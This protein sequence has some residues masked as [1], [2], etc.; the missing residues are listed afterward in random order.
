MISII[1]PTKN[2]EQNILNTVSHLQ[3]LRQ[4]TYC[5]IILVD[6]MSNDKTVQL[7]KPYVDKIIYSIPN[8]GIQQ[9]KGAAIAEG[10]MV[11]FLHADTHI[12]A[13]QIYMINEIIDDNSWGFFKISFDNNLLKYK[14]L[15]FFINLRST[16]FNYATG[17][18]VIFIKKKLF[19]KCNGFP[20][21]EIMEDIKICTTLNS[22]VKPIRL[23]SY[24]MTSCRRWQNNGFIRTILRMR[25]LRFL[26]FLKM[27]PS[28]LK[29]FYK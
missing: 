6:A 19:L 24:I 21:Y 13:E 3:K 4:D 10:E 17:D 29:A 15:S 1:I 18:Q 20:D 5:E 27:K 28:T 25:I 14:L 23:D 7:A 9:N 16:L 26:Y 22:F 2:E 12:D 11:L 8:R